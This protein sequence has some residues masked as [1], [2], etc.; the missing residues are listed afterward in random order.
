MKQFFYTSLLFLFAPI[1]VFGAVG[2]FE[3][4]AVVSPEDIIRYVVTLD[5]EGETINAVSGEIVISGAGSFDR[6]HTGTSVVG[7]WVEQPTVEGN[8]IQFSGVIPG[9]LGSSAM[10]LFDVFVES[11]GEGEMALL[12]DGEMFLHDGEGSMVAIDGKTKTISVETGAQAQPPVQD[13]ILPPEIFE[14]TVVRVPELYD[15]AYTI[16]FAA[17]DKGTGVEYYEIQES[18]DDEADPERWMRA[19]SPYELDDQNRDSHIFVKAVDHNG[20]VR[21]AVV[22]PERGISG[23]FAAVIGLIIILALALIYRYRRGIYER[24]RGET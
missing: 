7:L 8:K 5:T 16:I 20:N 15:S 24:Q 13:D 11:V 10:P 19:E 3:G 2:S 23:F 18:S 4:S 6:V 9:G 21:I 12:F 17:H 1:F 14:P 22:G